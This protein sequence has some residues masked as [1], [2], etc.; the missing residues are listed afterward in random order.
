MPDSVSFNTKEEPAREERV[1]VLL[2]RSSEWNG[3]IERSFQR[4]YRII[5]CL[6]EHRRRSVG[7]EGAP[8]PGSLSPREEKEEEQRSDKTVEEAEKALIHERCESMRPDDAWSKVAKSLGVSKKNLWRKRRDIYSE[9]HRFH[10]S[11]S[12]NQP[13]DK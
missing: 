7:T 11:N 3:Y 9:E 5:Q 12:F 6:K 2:S 4:D 13:E 8:I 1:L 10:P